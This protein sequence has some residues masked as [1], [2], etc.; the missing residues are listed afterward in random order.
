MIESDEIMALTA[1]DALQYLFVTR[2]WQGWLRLVINGLSQVE[3]AC[4]EIQCFNDL[5][6]C[7]SCELLLEHDWPSKNIFI[8]EKESDRYCSLKTASDESL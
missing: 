4:Q 2:I 3:E 8:L 6:S 1:N 5:L 7:Q